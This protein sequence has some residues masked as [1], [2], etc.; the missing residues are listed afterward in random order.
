[1]REEVVKSPGYPTLEQLPRDLLRSRRSGRRVL[2]RVAV[3]AEHDHSIAAVGDDWGAEVAR[4]LARAVRLRRA[5]LGYLAPLH[6]LDGA[7]DTRSVASLALAPRVHDDVA[8][9]RVALLL[10]L[11]R[12][13]L[14]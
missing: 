14:E 6:H 12:D 3:E 9:P 1:M 8:V 4:E 7:A 11:R 10:E 13:V 2:D 5:R